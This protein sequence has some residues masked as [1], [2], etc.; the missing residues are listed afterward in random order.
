MKKRILFYPK[1]YFIVEPFKYSKMNIV[2]RKLYNDMDKFSSIFKD[3]SNNNESKNKN[4]VKN[5][6]KSIRAI[7]KNDKKNNK[8]KNNCSP[9]TNNSINKS[10]FHTFRNRINSKNKTTYN[11]FNFKNLDNNS[12]IPLLN[13][14]NYQSKKSYSIN[15]SKTQRT[16]NSKFSY[17]NKLKNNN[18]SSFFLNN[19]DNK[20]IT[21]YF[22]IFN[23][24]TIKEINKFCLSSR[25]KRNIRLI[26]EKN[27]HIQKNVDIENLN[28]SKSSN[29]INSKN[30]K[31]SN[32]SIDNNK[33]KENN[34]VNNNESIINLNKIKIN[35]FF[36]PKKIKRIQ[37]KNKKGKY[38]CL[39]KREK[40]KIFDEIKEIEKHSE[41]KQQI[42]KR[43]KN[44][45]SKNKSMISLKIPKQIVFE[46]IEL[47]SKEEA[48]S[49]QKKIGHFYRRLD[50]GLYTSHFFTILRKDHFFGNDYIIHKTPKYYQ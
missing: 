11:F 31:D 36:F 7:S 5:K 15:F 24:N 2:L 29:I 37:I 14:R 21:N 46:D 45:I 33:W 19:K 26:K 28:L 6:L 27:N 47:E 41:E 22:K 48:T 23:N 20:K 32:I 35:K 30:N 49:Y 44:I 4:K 9:S 39:K 18:S 43:D 8:A 10:L 13:I 3:E 12:K 40:K 50:V 38:T 25:N 1:N 34:N 17:I 42:I 16:I